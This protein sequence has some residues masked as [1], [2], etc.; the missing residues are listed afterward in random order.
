MFYHA[1]APLTAVVDACIYSSE[2]TVVCA[3]SSWTTSVATSLGERITAVGL[4]PF[5]VSALSNRLWD[6]TAAGSLCRDFHT[7]LLIKK[8]CVDP[9]RHRERRLCV[10]SAVQSVTALVQRAVVLQSQPL[11]SEATLAWSRS[12]LMALIELFTLQAPLA[13]S[14]TRERLLSEKM[15]DDPTVSQQEGVCDDAHP[16]ATARNANNRRYVELT[17]ATAS[18]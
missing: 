14:E 11:L 10:C 3:S 4:P 5:Y 17:S 6:A 8:T 18:S 12:A 9:G 13:T 16:T 7:I 15:R 1:G 2:R